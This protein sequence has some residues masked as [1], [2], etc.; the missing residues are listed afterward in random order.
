MIAEP[1]FRVPTPQEE[2]LLLERIGNPGDLSMEEEAGWPTQAQTWEKDGQVMP[3]MWMGP[4]EHGQIPRIRVLE[5]WNPNLDYVVPPFRP[6][7]LSTRTQDPKFNLTPTDSEGWT[8]WVHP[9]FQDKP[10]LVAQKPGSM[11]SF[12]LATA[13]GVIKIYTLKSRTF[14]LGTI[15]CWVD[16]DWEKA[17]RVDGYWDKDP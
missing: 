6:V 15:E 17:V 3:G 5:G 12:Q 9:E 1:G 10:Y 13:L 11:V 8:T 2:D 16:A 14:G 4:Y 7:C